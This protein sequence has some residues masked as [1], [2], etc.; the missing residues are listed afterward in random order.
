MHLQSVDGTH[1]VA[2]NDSRTR[3][4]ILALDEQRLQLGLCVIHPETQEEYMKVRYELEP[5][6]D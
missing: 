3:Y 5:I 6:E 4:E 1:S 2:F